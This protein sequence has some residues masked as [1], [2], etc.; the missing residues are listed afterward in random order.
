[1]HFRKGSHLRCKF[2]DLE[3]VQ[4]EKYVS[5][6][7][8]VCFSPPQRDLTTVVRVAVTNN[9]S[10]FTPNPVFFTYT[11]TADLVSITPKFGGISGGTE[12]LI[13]WYNLEINYDGVVTCRIGGI[14]TIGQV[15]ASNVVKCVTPTVKQPGKQL[16]QVSVNGLSSEEIGQG[17]EESVFTTPSLYF[18]FVEDI[19]IYE[20]IPDLGPSIDAN[21]VMTVRGRWFMNSVDLACIFL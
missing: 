2:G 5:S 11:T 6:T 4:V 21:T 16:A 12:L 1:M 18:E 7:E 14:N 10:T 9:N 17:F 3:A 19:V 8:V 20:L 13:R 15:L